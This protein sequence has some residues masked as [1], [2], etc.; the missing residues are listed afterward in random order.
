MT[1]MKEIT[2]GEIES[3]N[4]E[5]DCWMVLGNSQTGGPMVYDITLYLDDHPGG[6]EVLLDLAG[7]DG[8][9][10]FE[11]IGHSQDA[12]DELKRYRIG[13]LKIDEAEIARRIAAAEAAL[14]KANS[15]TNNIVMVLV[16]LFAVAVG[17]YITQFMDNSEGID[18]VSRNITQTAEVVDGGCVDGSDIGGCG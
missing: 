8:D 12:R 4:T 5:E 6:A 9:E 3:H 17:V 11:D 7:Q 18:I 10:F 14:G 16:V 15:E 13:T 2:M 1:E